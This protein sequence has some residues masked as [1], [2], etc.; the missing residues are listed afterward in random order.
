MFLSA[1]FSKAQLLLVGGENEENLP[2]RFN[3]AEIKE[4]KIRS[5]ILDII[6]KKDFQLAE[7]KGLTKVFEFDGEGRL[8]RCYQTV[9]NKIIQKEFHSQPVYRHRRL[10]NGGG[11]YYKNAYEYDTLSHNY[12]YDAGG[13]LIGKR[14]KDGDFYTAAYYKYDSINRLKN[15]ISARETNGSADKGVFTLG[16]QQI[17]FE[18][19]Y[20]YIIT[21]S[22]QYKQQY[23]NDEGRVFKEVIVT[24]DE[25]GKPLQYNESYI[26]TWINQKTDFTYNAKEQLIEKKYTSNASGSIELK[27]TYEYENE[28]LNTIKQF[29]NG[30]LMN[31]TGFVYD[32]GT[33]LPSSYVTRDYID[34]SMR[35]VKII[36]LN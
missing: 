27:D 33:K 8:R 26:T 12:F 31:E 23:L 6:D 19:N 14:Y 18:E 11:V 34:K 20:K 9:V 7:D 4:K 30:T 29:K 2:F 25:K 16:M 36:Y 22:K 5:V 35:I 32:T 24:Q 15:V 10:V 13:N 3:P 28:R 1:F 21:G 17:S